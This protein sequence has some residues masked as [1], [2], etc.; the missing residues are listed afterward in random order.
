MHTDPEAHQVAGLSDNYKA[1][2]EDGRRHERYC[3]QFD[4]VLDLLTGVVLGAGVVVAYVLLGG[5]ILA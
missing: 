3:R 4:G 5:S 2:Y 1:G